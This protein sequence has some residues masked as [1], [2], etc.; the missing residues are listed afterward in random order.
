M[1]YILHVLILALIYSLF[2]SSLN[3]QLG[4]AGLYNF[5]QVA[6]FAIGAYTTALLTL[7]GLPVAVGWISA[8]AIAGFCGLVIAYPLLR[9]T[10]DYFGVASLA[11]AEIVRILLLNE[12]WLTKGPMGIPGIPRPTWLGLPANSLVQY[13]IIVLVAGAAMLAVLV[14]VGRSPFGRFLKVIREDEEVARAFGRDIVSYKV[15]CVMIS[16]GAAGLAG[17][18]WA[19][20][21]TYISPADFTIEV[22]I[23]VLLCVVLGGRGTFAGPV[24]GAFLVILVQEA[25]RFLPLPPEWGRLVVPIQGIIFGGVLVAMM[26]LRPQGFVAEHRE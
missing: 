20:Y 2:A 24:L 3:L 19:H 5:G 16:A 1:D 10:G 15:R 13:L 18:M 25:V 21:V 9:L 4:L 12:R 11:F 8:I 22:T 14:V 26:I 7:G 17:A 23:L 6:F